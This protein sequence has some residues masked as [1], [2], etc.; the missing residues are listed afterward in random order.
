MIPSIYIKYLRT[1]FN[2]FFLSRSFELLIYLIEI[3]MC[4]TLRQWRIILL[5]CTHDRYYIYMLLSNIRFVHLIHLVIIIN[6]FIIIKSDG[7][8]TLNDI[9]LVSILNDSTLKSFQ[10]YW[11]K[12]LKVFFSMEVDE[13]NKKMS[14]LNFACNV[15]DFSSLLASN[16]FAL[17]YFSFSHKLPQ[18]ICNSFVCVWK[19]SFYVNAVQPTM[20]NQNFYF[21]KA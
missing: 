21:L 8:V 5:A 2:Y 12:W 9:L 4:L 11:T 10:K 3:I 15:I 17:E 20:R 18:E 1:K 13:L 19:S 16:N 7:N 14:W 6:V